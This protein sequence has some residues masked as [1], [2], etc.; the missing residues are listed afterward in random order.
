MTARTGSSRSHRRRR[1]QETRRRRRRGTAAVEFALTF[2]V[3]LLAFLAAF[4][5]Y[6]LV[7][8][9]RALED[10]VDQ[11]LRY[12]SVRS[13]SASLAQIGAVAT[14]TATT[15]LGAAGAAVS[16]SVSVTPDDAPGSSLTVTVSDAWTPVLLGDVFPAVTL[17]S[18]GSVTVQ[19]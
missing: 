15:L 19:N 4:E 17:S 14:A 13:A 7:A 18:S 8:T 16:S 1:D 5:L 3:L 10:A 11:A 9:Q 12:G 6:R 2:P